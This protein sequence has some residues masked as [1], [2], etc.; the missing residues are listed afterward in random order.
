[1]GLESLVYPILGDRVILGKTREEAHKPASGK[2]NGYGGKPNLG[3]PILDCACRELK[4]ESGLIAL[5][6]DLIYRAYIQFFMFGAKEPSHSVAIFLVKKFSGELVDTHEMKEHK[7]FLISN[8]QF[9]L[10]LP[11][12]KFFLPIVLDLEQKGFSGWMR[13][14]ENRRSV[15]DHHFKPYLKDL[16]TLRV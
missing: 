7:P 9:N 16:N 5:P 15:D 10:M 2:Y 11:T 1:M 4:D 14:S 8:P 3:E 12:D 6:E 13:F